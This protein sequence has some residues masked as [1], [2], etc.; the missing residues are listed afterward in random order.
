MV[1]PST[2]PHWGHLLLCIVLSL[3]SDRSAAADAYDGA[4]RKNLD[5]ENSCWASPVATCNR[6][7]T[8]SHGGDWNLK[9]PYDSLPAFNNAY[10]NG[11]DAVKG[12]FRVSM[13][14]IGMVM[15]SSPIEFY[16]SLSCRGKYV[17]KMTAAECEQCQMAFTNYTFIS[18]PT[19]LAWAAD[20]VN[21]MLCVK[22]SSDLPRAIT[23]LLEND[24]SHRAFL[25]V[26]LS[27]YLSLDLNSVPHWNDVYYVVQVNN[28]EQIDALLSS[29][30]EQLSRAVL[31]EFHHWQDWPTP[32]TLKASIA[33]VQAGNRRTFAASKDS[34]V[35]ATVNDHLD[36]FNM[37]FDVA[38]TYNLGNA[39]EARAQINTERGLTPP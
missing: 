25:E 37:G 27:D 32:D 35:T 30:A 19:F 7:M 39:V 18:V 5:G 15:H 13:D 17:E 10:I 1:T 33:A 31:F 38:Y 21:V 36:L 24:A 2:R 16:E 26:D 22:E 23:T 28:A 34:P 3:Y 12:D 6:V 20:K 9:Y 8:T 29:S 14:N 11:A 4:W